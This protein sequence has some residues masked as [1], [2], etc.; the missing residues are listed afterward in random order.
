M[1]MTEKMFVSKVEWISSSDTSM[2]GTVQSGKR[3][4]K[5]AS[6]REVTKVQEYMYADSQSS[7]IGIYVL[8]L[9]W[10]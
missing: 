7:G 1:A 6:V 3:V 9:S 2:A 4:S 10:G 8:P 5:G